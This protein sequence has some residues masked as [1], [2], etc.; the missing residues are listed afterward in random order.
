MC[1]F[2]CTVCNTGHSLN[3]YTYVDDLIM[4]AGERLDSTGIIYV[5]CSFMLMNL[6]L[7]CIK[8]LAFHF[9]K[10]II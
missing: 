8:I 4:N 6:F 3:L 10:H 2:V 9:S 5:N 7:H 1:L